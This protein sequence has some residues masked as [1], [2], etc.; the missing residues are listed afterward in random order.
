[1]LFRPCDLFL[2]VH[3]IIRCGEVAQ[4]ISEINVS[5]SLINRLLS[6][7]IISFFCV[8]VF[9]VCLVRLIVIT[10]H[11]IVVLALM[12]SWAT[13]LIR[14]IISGISLFKLGKVLLVVG[15]VFAANREVISLR[16]MRV[17]ATFQFIFDVLFFIF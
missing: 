6:S 16:S 10:K 2:V 8:V 9:I 1:M 14:C 5:F 17:L 15:N 3:V 7:S 12:F 4:R 11:D 13:R